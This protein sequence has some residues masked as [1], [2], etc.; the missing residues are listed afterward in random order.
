MANTPNHPFF[1]AT[2]C[3]VLYH[4]QDAASEGY[5]VPLHSHPFW[6]LEIILE[7]SVQLRLGPEIFSA[8]KRAWILIAPNTR[9]SLH[10]RRD[11]DYLSIKFSSGNP[12]LERITGL[13]ASTERLGVLAQLFSQLIP[14]G[15]QVAT[16]NGE[17]EHAL[18]LGILHRH[19]HGSEESASSARVNLVDKAVQLVDMSD[20]RIRSVKEV[21][22]EIGCNAD[23]LSNRFLKARGKSLKMHINLRR[24]QKAKSL[25]AYS[26]RRVG[27]IA[28]QVGFDDIYSFSRFFSRQT[29]KSPSM[30]RS[31]LRSTI[32]G[33][34]RKTPQPD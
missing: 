1:K 28:E 4:R 2:D 12:E 17:L 33:R 15:E 32:T 7:G 23:Y 19:L 10:Y 30:Y 5:R 16:G 26:E 6:Q 21:A 13:W 18:T 25:L 31:K 14:N 29:G 11:T 27:E 22:R 9:H 24:I 34:A 8:F 20:G 3:T